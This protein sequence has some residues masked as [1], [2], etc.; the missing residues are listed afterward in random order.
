MIFPR[1][2]AL[3]EVLWSPKEKKDWKD[4]ERRLPELLKRYECM[5]IQITAMLIMICKHQL[6]PTENYEGSLWKI[7][8]KNKERM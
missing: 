2:S 3:S 8:S 4:F 5:E 6:L 1:M 7:E